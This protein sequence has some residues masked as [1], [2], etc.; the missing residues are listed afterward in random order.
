[1]AGN[2][3]KAAIKKPG[4]LHEELG[5]S[6]K[7]KIPPYLIAQ[8]AQKGGKLGQRARFAQTLAGMNK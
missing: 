5:V 2:F 1:M 4:A 7:K 3:I 8:A 6:K